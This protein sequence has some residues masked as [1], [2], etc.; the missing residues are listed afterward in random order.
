MAMLSSILAF[1]GGRLAGSLVLG[2]LSSVLVFGVWN[3]FDKSGM[4]RE[5][6]SL[7][8]KE[9][10]LAAYQNANAS[11]Q[12]ML[13]DEQARAA[14]AQARFS[15]FQHKNG[16]LDQ[17]NRNLEERLSALIDKYEDVEKWSIRSIPKPITHGLLQPTNNALQPW[18]EFKVRG[19]AAEG[20]PGRVYSGRGDRR[21]TYEGPVGRA[22]PDWG[23]PAMDRI[24]ID[25]AREPGFFPLLKV[26]GATVGSNL[27]SCGRRVYRS[28]WSPYES[29]PETTIQIGHQG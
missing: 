22:S 29:A 4:E 9:V 18:P 8:G 23:D 25:G 16:E 19:A 12:L 10:Q 28:C 11:L 14:E 24:R 6:D 2:A 3:Y 7:R 5:L 21:A 15:V 13:E 27:Q 1:F 17:D 20:L 26:S